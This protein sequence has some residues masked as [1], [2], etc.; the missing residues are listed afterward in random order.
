MDH[1]CPKE[2]LGL[3]NT[4]RREP[5]QIARH[6]YAG[7]PARRAEIVTNT[8]DKRRQTLGNIRTHF[9]VFNNAREGMAKDYLLNKAV[10]QRK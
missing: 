10:D 1:P 6:Q 3:V 2:A 8:K 7:Y 4:F 9:M 5:S